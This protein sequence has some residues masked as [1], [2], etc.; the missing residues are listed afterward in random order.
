MIVVTAL[1]WSVRT[2]TQS[3]LR[4]LQ[5]ESAGWM[6]AFSLACFAIGTAAY[7]FYTP[8]GKGDRFMLSMYAPLVLTFVWITERF[9]RQMR[10][11][12]KA[13]LTRRVYIAMQSVLLLAISWRLID[14]LRTPL[15][16]DI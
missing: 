13:Q 6:L 10:H 7:G 2:E 16:R 15:F 5:S 11:T 12:S 8:I 14:L 1:R 9:R 3:G 4:S